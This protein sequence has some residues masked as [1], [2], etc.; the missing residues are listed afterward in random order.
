MAI[1]YK[2]PRSS[3]GKALGYRQVDPGIREVEIF[4]HFFVS[5][6]VLG[7]TQPPIK[8]MFSHGVK[9]VELMTNHIA[10]S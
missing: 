4:L 5:R 2:L 10:T 8:R 9:A 7:Y 3:N 6:L 1:I